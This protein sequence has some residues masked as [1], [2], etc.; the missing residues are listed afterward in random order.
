MVD[1]LTDTMEVGLMGVSWLM[2]SWFVWRLV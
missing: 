2:V 1:G